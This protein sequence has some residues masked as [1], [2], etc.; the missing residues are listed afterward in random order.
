MIQTFG[1]KRW[2]LTFMLL[3]QQNDTSA[4]LRSC[5]YDSY[6]RY[7]THSTEDLFPRFPKFSFIFHVFAT[8]TIEIHI[9]SDILYSFRY[10]KCKETL[11]TSCSLTLLVFAFPAGGQCCSHSHK[12][13]TFLSK[14]WFKQPF[15]TSVQVPCPPLIF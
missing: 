6:S 5:S 9:V 3:Y 11:G 7:L 10:P 8:A 15:L 1:P 2:N 4:N 14:T 13:Q 12:L